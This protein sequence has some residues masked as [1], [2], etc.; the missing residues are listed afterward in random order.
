MQDFGCKFFKN[1][2]VSPLISSAF[3]Q[4]LTIVLKS[5]L[6][7]LMIEKNA[8]IFSACSKILAAFFGSSLSYLVIKTNALEFSR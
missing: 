7:H 6:V 3:S 5:S 8:L 2:L 1:V 4:I